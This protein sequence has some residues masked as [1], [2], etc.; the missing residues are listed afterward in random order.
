LKYE[1]A[2]LSSSGNTAL[3]ARSI[4]SI[5]PAENT[6]LTDLS[7]GSV[8]EIADVYFIGF[9]VNRG[10]VPLKIIESLEYTEGKTVILFITSGI[11]PI[12]SYKAA[13]ERKISPFLPDNC[14]YKGL[15]LCAG[16]F[17]DAAA[18]KIKEMLRLQ[19]ENEQ[20]RMLWENYQKTY[21]HPNNRDLEDLRNF[22]LAVLE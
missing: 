8:S 4:A 16:Q 2:Y 7:L 15:F 12:D 3:L 10:T 1:I 20:A 14:N 19:P 6:H 5:L 18:S 21:G 17:P 22:V 11:E 13:I 9:G